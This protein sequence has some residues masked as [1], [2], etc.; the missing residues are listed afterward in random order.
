MKIRKEIKEENQMRI[1]S[2]KNRTKK[3]KTRK[4]RRILVQ[5]PKRNSKRKKEKNR[6][7]YNCEK[8]HLLE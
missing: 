6:R 4:L 3:K 8:Y 5:E 1:N 7:K 2:F